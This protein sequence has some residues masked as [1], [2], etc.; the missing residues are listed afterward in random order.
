MLLLKYGETNALKL[1]NV[2][3]VKEV[4]VNVEEKKEGKDE[5]E[6]MEKQVGCGVGWCLES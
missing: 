3:M 5:Q 6:K 4:V 1:G 2:V